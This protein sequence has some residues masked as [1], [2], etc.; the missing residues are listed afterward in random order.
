MTVAQSHVVD[1]FFWVLVVSRLLYVIHRNL[2]GRPGLRSV[3]DTIALRFL[4][5][6]FGLSLLVFIAAF[7]IALL[8]A[9]VWVSPDG[10]RPA[11]AWD[12]FGL[13]AVVVV[14][15]SFSIGPLQRWLR[16]PQDHQ[17]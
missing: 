3:G 8:N 16:R 11:A 2:F 17:R 7:V 15:A 14:I 6:V 9:T 12:Y 10:L 5:T 1:Q 13:V 4:E